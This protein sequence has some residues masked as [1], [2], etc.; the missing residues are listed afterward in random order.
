MSETLRIGE[1]ASAAG[2][3]PRTVRYYEK[4]GLV[5]EATRT[6]SGYRAYDP[7]TQARLTKIGQLKE[8]GLSL[9]DIASVIDLYFEDPTGVSGKRAA[10][11]IL[12]KHLADARRRRQEMEG[13]ER[14]LLASI[15]RITGLLTRAEAGEFH[16]GAQTLPDCTDPGDA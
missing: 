8:L 7:S 9:D 10:L 4:L 14:D 13:L 5:P 11:A 16:F 1:L 6:A 15:E 12:Q 3:T 2:V